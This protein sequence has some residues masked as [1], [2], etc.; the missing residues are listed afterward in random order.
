M[1]ILIE[2]VR[3]NNMT[4]AA[5]NLYISQSTIS[6]TIS[7]IEDQY[8]IKIFDRTPKKLI[9][10]SEGLALLDYCKK[11][12]DLHEQMEFT[13]K[14]VKQISISIGATIITASSILSEIW[15]EYHVNC[16]EVKSRLIMDELDALKFKLLNCK[17]DFILTEEEIIHPDLICAQFCTDDYTF[18]CH[19]NHP[20][21]DRK[22][23]TLSEL[24]GEP[25]LLREE[26]NLTRTLVEQVMNEH[27]IPYTIKNCFN[28]IDSLK[29]GVI[30]GEGVSLLASK[31]TNI[32]GHENKL[33]SIPITDFPHKRK[34]FVIYR[35]DTDFKEKPHLKKFVDLLMNMNTQLV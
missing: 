23:I 7:A 24:A 26:G 13:L 34:I 31:L 4:A 12:V 14:H 9:I 8:D 30:R 1:K 33:I 3:F 2:V 28:N 29:L 21:A 5:K 10:T 16:P 19:Q 22:S 15:F 32:S 27:N 11:I 20:M 35:R 25:F 6:Q 18:V 17:L